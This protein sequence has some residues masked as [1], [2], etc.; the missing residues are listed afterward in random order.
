MQRIR[1]MAPTTLLAGAIAVLGCGDVPVDT[2]GG[3]PVAGVLEG[4]VTYSGP[5][6]CSQGGHVVGNAVILVFDARNPPPPRGLGSTAA[7]FGVIAGD[8]LF[9]ALPVTPGADKVCPPADAPPVEVTAPFVISPLDAG[10]Y[11]VEAFFDTTGDFFP[12]LKPRNLP[13][14][15][16]IGGGFIDVTE[17]A[18]HGTDS[19]Y[20]PTFLPVNVGVPG[21]IPATSLHGVP[22]FTMPPQGFVAG[23]ISVA[24]GARLTLARPYFYP[25]GAVLPAGQ[26]NDRVV[27]DSEAPSTAQRPAQSAPTDQNPDA[28]L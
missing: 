18:A 7:N 23:G 13:E 6:P 4:S 15:T 14:A 9:G 2:T 17:A 19:N 25:E 1:P 24:I 10:S 27:I 20:L 21:A 11:V 3:F 22:D 5:P 12:T 28:R 16:D 26:S 8:V